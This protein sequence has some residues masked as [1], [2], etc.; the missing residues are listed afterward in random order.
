MSDGD[1][2]KIELLNDFFHLLRKFDEGAWDKLML[3]KG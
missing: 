3:N 2:Q 1:E